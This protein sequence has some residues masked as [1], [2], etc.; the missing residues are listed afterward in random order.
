MVLSLYTYPSVYLWYIYKYGG[1]KLKCEVQPYI[2]AS[3]LG[4]Q[5]N[6]IL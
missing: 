4:K 3:Y 1:E 5:V 6:V 2:V